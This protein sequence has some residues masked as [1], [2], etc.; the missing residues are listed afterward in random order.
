MKPRNI[1]SMLQEGLVE[2]RYRL[3][4]IDTEGVRQEL[5]DTDAE[6]KS[7]HREI[8]KIEAEIGHQ[9][10]RRSELEERLADL[11]EREGEVA[12][13]EADLLDEER[14]IHQYLH[15]L[16]TKGAGT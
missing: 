7:L 14:R 4:E 10:R 5:A 16:K 12:A 1:I 13:L 3:Q 8:E 2:I 15:D 6:I 9:E 11:E